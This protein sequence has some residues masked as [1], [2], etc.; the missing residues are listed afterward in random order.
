MNKKQ[1]SKIN[2]SIQELIKTCLELDSI[3]SFNTR[4]KYIVAKIKFYNWLNEEDVETICEKLLLDVNTILQIKDK[5]NEK[6]LYDFYIHQSSS[7]LEYLKEVYEDN[8]DIEN[9][10]KIL[11]LWN[12]CQCFTDTNSCIEKYPDYKYYINY[13]WKKVKRYKSNKS[14][15]K[16]VKKLED[17]QEWLNRSYIDQ[18]EVWQYGRCGGWLSI[19]KESELEFTY[20]YDNYYYYDFNLLLEE[21]DNDKFNSIFN[22]LEE[23]KYKFLSDLKSEYSY[24]LKKIQAIKSII[25]NI[26]SMVKN[27]KT[28]LLD[29]L[30]D[31]IQIFL[32]P[33]QSC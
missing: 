4:D 25:D 33:N 16:Y 6:F 26:E 8:I 23:D 22:K 14:W 3:E 24:H 17:Y 19:C 9:Y 5:F 1:L 27:Y 31:E 2:L 18:F 28:T 29:L 21:T 13:Y 30:E 12:K 20:L 10:G 7:E 15:K 11:S 32:N